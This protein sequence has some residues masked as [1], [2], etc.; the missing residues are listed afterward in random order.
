MSTRL[1]AA[2]GSDL[3]IKAFNIKLHE[4]YEE[5]IRKNSSETL[6]LIVTCINRAVI[7]MYCFLQIIT[8]IFI[9]AF[10]FGILLLISWKTILIGFFLLG[11]SYLTIAYFIK[12]KMYVNSKKIISASETQIRTILE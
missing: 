12:K 1:S 6:S 11:M 8:N 7:G 9:G 2:I 5:Q 3:S 10:I 4:S